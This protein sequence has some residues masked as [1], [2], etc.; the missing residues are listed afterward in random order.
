MKT[1]LSVD[2][3]QG[4]IIKLS[5]EMPI[6]E[7][8]IEAAVGRYLARDLVASRTQPAEHTSAMDGYAISG[9]SRGPWQIIG[10]SRAGEPFKDLVRT[11]E[12][13]RISTG[14]HLPTGTDR[15]LI[16]ENISLDR[17][18]LHCLA[19]FP[20]AV[21]HVRTKGFDFKSGDV[22]LKAGTQVTATQVALA[23]A[24]GHIRVP[25]RRAPKIAIL[26][27]GSELAAY[28]EDC[29]FGQIPATNGRMIGA[30]LS[31]ANCVSMHFGPIKD[32]LNEIQKALVQ[33]KEADII[34]TT[35]GASVGDHDLVQTALESWGASIKFWKVSMKP[36]KPIMVAK[37]G[38]QIILGLP[39]NPVSAFVTCFILVLPLIRAVLG[40]SQPKPMVI[41]LI[42]NTDIPDAGTRD[43][44]LRGYRVGNSVTLVGSQDSSA[45]S[46]LS[47]SNCLIYRPAREKGVRE[48]D[49]VPCYLFE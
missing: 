22:V 10:E 9:E 43:E 26:E 30:L 15:V 35:G 5:E 23:L 41:N 37:R 49:T 20:D 24:S 16:Q 44:F 27:T 28:P 29:E 25:V 19:D 6:E 13:V 14:A 12:T 46:A 1:M 48:G 33:S 45:L 21:R 39:G 31:K 4:R 11:G 17:R 8:E 36:G 42:A 2:Q 47:E 34:L 7:V 32:D 40:A 3:A 18:E 38:S